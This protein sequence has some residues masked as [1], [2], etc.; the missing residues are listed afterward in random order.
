MPSSWGSCWVCGD[1]EQAE[2][3]WPLSAEVARSLSRRRK[4][5]N[6]QRLLK[7]DI[8]DNDSV[9][10]EDGLDSGE[11]GDRRLVNHLHL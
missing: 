8:S 6:W 5:G 1:R 9:D 3:G 7:I 10:R 11:T 2:V 4:G